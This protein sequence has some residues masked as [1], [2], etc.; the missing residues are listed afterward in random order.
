MSMNLY[1]QFLDLLP[2]QPT[3]AGEITHVQ[4]D[5]KAV[6][7]LPGGGY[8]LAYAGEYQVGNKV[9]VKD[10]QIQALAPDLPVLDITV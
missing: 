1:R 3:M 4:G 2:R 5:G 9:F 8:L 10:G 6:I 7:S